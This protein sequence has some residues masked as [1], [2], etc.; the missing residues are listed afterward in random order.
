M[1]SVEIHYSYPTSPNACE[2]GFAKTGCYSIYAN[3][4]REDSYATLR[5][6]VEALLAQSGWEWSAHWVRCHQAHYSLADQ[7]MAMVE[8]LQTA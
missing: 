7:V 3:D 2:T 6:A 8:E 4:L 5:E 1:R